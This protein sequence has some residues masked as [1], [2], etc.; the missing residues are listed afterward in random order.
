MSYIRTYEEFNWNPFKKEEEEAPLVIP[1]TFSLN[2]LFLSPA[3]NNALSNIPRMPI[4]DLFLSLKDI[5][6]DKLVNN[7]VNYL[8][9]DKEGNMSYL[10]KRDISP[11]DQGLFNQKYYHAPKR[12]STR[13]NRVLPKIL[14]AEYLINDQR[15][16]ERFVN[17]WK[18]VFESG[19]VVEEL[20]G[21]DILRAYG[22]TGEMKDTGGSCAATG[23]G[24]SKFDILVKNPNNFSALVV[25]EQKGIIGRRIAI[26]G[27][28]TI[29]SGVFR[30]GQHYTML[31]NFY[32]KG[33]HGSATDNLM[34]NFARS[35]GYRYTND[36]PRDIIA[37]QHL[38]RDENVFRVR[39]D[40]TRVGSSYPPFDGFFVNFQTNEVSNYV[41]GRDAGWQGMYGANP[42]GF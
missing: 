12:Q 6:P 21:S 19:L 25:F 9:V 16:V 33:G 35:K 29:D 30:R 22:F 27:I 7:Y 38:R 5:D 1:S 42:R 2:T 24:K 36:G 39:I 10:D 40:N 23:H 14:K 8:D 3:L 34:L 31:N 11:E 20:I 4:A 18:A 17:A 28:Q 37:N 13:P 15:E 32:G 26:K 41:S